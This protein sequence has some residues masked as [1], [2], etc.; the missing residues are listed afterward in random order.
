VYPQ[1]PVTLVIG[2]PP[3]GDA[4]A[5]AR[6][7]TKHMADDLGERM[8]V[9]YKPG[10]AGNIGAESVSRAEPGGYTLYLGARPNT[11]HKTMYGHLKYDF[12]RDLLPIGLVAT[13]PYVIVASKHAPSREAARH[14]G[15]ITGHCRR[16]A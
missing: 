9:A 8:I 11:I 15:H 12:F 16:R 1:R 6:I 10:A 7:L 4:D 2:F 5:L 13:M 3:G 14:R